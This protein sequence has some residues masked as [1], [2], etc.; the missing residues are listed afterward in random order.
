MNAFVR[1]YLRDR[2]EQSRGQVLVVVAGG[3]LLFLAMV[4]LVIDLGF[5]FMLRRQEQTA[6]DPGALAAARYIPS[7][8]TTAMWDAACFYATQNGFRPTKSIG[9]RCDPSG[10]DDSILTMSWPP[11]RDAGAYAGDRSYVQV[12]ITQPHRHDFIATPVRI[13]PASR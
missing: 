12:T 11:G 7:A 1:L 6:A 4:A 9:G 2:R 13:R 10:N 3:M 5:A 8:N